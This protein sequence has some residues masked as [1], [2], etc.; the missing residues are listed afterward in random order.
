MFL[1]T[2]WGRQSVVISPKGWLWRLFA[3]L[4]IKSQVKCQLIVIYV[5]KFLGLSVSRLC[6]V[7]WQLGSSTFSLYRRFIW[8][9]KL[10][11]ELFQLILCVLF[12]FSFVFN[13]LDLLHWAQ[14]GPLCFDIRMDYLFHLFYVKV[15]GLY[16]G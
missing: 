8:L 5:F 10:I 2:H 11:G 7:F 1:K 15:F 6:D 4:V 13:L 12:P 16:M 9:N 3:R 14:F